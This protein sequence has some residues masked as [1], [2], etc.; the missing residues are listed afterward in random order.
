[1]MKLIKNQLVM[2]VLGISIGLAIFLIGLILK[3]IAKRS[4]LQS[5]IAFCAM[6]GA[7]LIAVNLLNLIFHLVRRKNPKFRHITD[8]ALKDERNIIIRNKAG[9]LTRNIFS[10]L[11]G[12]ALF[13]FVAL[14]G[15]S[16]FAWTLFGLVIIDSILWIVLYTYYDKRL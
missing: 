10:W 8:I 1:M 15:I 9:T 2:S 14:E 11:L 5:M 4:D 16:W 12:L 13:I 6:L 7:A 3:F